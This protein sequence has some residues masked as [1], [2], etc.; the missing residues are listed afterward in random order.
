MAHCRN[1]G[2][3]SHCGSN[4]RKDF[5]NGDTVYSS[6]VEVCKHCIC[7]ACQTGKKDIENEL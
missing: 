3:E 4:L 5:Y 7:D 1:C 6:N 2:H